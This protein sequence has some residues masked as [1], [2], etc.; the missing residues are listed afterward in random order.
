MAVTT[1]NKHAA[2]TKSDVTVFDEE[3]SI[4]VGGAGDIAL[5]LKGDSTAVTYT[6]PA[7]TFLPCNAIQ[8]LETGTTATNIIRGYN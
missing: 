8:V 2:V 6:V 3:S 4:Y 7:G 5:V 1:F